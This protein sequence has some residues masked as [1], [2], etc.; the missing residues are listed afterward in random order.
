MTSGILPEY[1]TP[2]GVQQLNLFD[3]GQHRANIAQLMK[4]LG[5]INPGWE[6]CGCAS[7][8]GS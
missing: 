1:F 8:C 6:T 4:V 3:G 2:N 7:G 5:G